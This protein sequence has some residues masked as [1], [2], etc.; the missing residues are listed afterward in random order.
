MW[1]TIRM[2]TQ[3]P[4]RFTDPELEALDE[5]VAHGLAGSRS[6]LIRVAVARVVDEHRREQIGQRIVAAYTDQPQTAEEDELALGAAIA[7]TESEP[8]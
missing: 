2:T 6:E 5:L 4:T 7:L 3:V 1:Y 8:W